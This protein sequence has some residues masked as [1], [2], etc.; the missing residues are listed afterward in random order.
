MYGETGTVMRQEFAELLRQ[1]RVQQRLGETPVTRQERGLQIRQYRQTVLIW[2]SQAMAAT[3]PLTFSNHTPAQPNPFRHAGAD[4]GAPAGELGRAIDVAKER[5]TASPASS[6]QLTTPSGLPFLEH[7]RG[8]ARA[9]ALAEHDTATDIARRMTAPQAQAVV[10]DVAAIAQALV[11]LD[12]R[13]RS[14]PGWEQLA[15][16][17]RLGWAALATAL[18]VSLGQPDYTVDALG[19]RP[20]T[21]LID[22]PPRPGVLG[23][24][25]AE[26]NLVVRMRSFPN[27]TN[28]RYVVDSQRLL[29]RHLVPFAERIDP[30]LAARWAERAGTYALLQQQ[31]RRIGGHIGKGGYAAAEGANAISRLRALP[32]D[33]IVEPRV[34]SGFQLLFD[35]LD[36]RIADVIEDG[37][38]RRA[39]FQRVTVP[40]LVG[41]SGDLVAPL[42]ERF[43]PVDRTANPELIATVRGRLRPRSS[44]VVATPGASRADLHAALIH[45]PASGEPSDVRRL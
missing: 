41:D 10:G 45:R 5:S 1:H 22:G 25:Q 16:G 37:I 30:R 2:C 8:A 36:H 31:L 42:Q 11:I 4:G 3:S 29:S 39:F 12:Q 17:S 14:T 34:L 43:V 27:A 21:K 15:Q 23:V 38:D 32:A 33:T 28:L 24:L 26:H 44:S 7:W 9:A 13:Y 35:R 19:W 18:D 6:Q 20:K 40:Q